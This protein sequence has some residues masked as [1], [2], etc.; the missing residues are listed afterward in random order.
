MHKLLL[1]RLANEI[2]NRVDVASNGCH[3]SQDWYDADE[4]SGAPDGMSYFDW[5]EQAQTDLIKA[6]NGL[7][8]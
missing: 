5:I 4:N 1:K 6:I 7:P 8:D 2:L 3:N